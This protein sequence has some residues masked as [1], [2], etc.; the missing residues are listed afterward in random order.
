MR[1]DRDARRAVTP[2]IDT[3]ATTKLTSAAA[4]TN[5]QITA[6]RYRLGPLPLEP[7][8]GSGV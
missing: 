2:P 7:L 4:M 1:R 8:P 3:A 6:G 5:T